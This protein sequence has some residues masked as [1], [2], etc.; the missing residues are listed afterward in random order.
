[1]LIQNHN[2][3]LKLWYVFQSGIFLSFCQIEF[4]IW[5]RSTASNQKSECQHDTRP[6]NSILNVNT[7]PSS[8]PTKTPPP[9]RARTQS[10]F[11]PFHLNGSNASPRSAALDDAL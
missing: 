2:V 4:M 10:R 1:M 5:Q 3:K 8:S 7:S 11:K 9:K 6:T